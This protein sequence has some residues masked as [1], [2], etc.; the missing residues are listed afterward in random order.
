MPAKSKAQQRFM[1]MLS[2]NAQRA[3]AEGVPMKVAR[4]FAH[5]PGGTT[6]NLPERKAKKK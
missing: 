4:E 5:A 3:K 2:E 6:K 1:G